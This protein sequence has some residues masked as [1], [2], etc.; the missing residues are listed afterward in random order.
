MAKE[1]GI[2]R[3]G[4][5][6]DTH[7]P[8]YGELP[9]SLFEK[10]EKMDVIIHLGD[11]CDLQTY[12]KFQ[13][14]SPVIAVYGNCDH[15]DLRAQLPEKKKLE[16]GGYTL[17]L[18]HG[19]GPRKNLEKRVVQVFSDVDVILFGHSHVPMWE[20]MGDVY[21]F[22]PGSVSMNVEGPGTYGILELGETMEHRF[23]PLV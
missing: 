21:V 1:S 23:V 9:Q 11:F 20:K 17:G 5:V 15:P 3:I 22:N 6:S 2:T 12:M 4:V 10:L 7:V 19:W 13:K 8:D 18:I 14:V 16:I